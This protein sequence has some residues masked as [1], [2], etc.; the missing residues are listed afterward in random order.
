MI[1]NFPQAQRLRMKRA[2]IAST[3][4]TAEDD[5]LLADCAAGPIAI[6]LG[7]AADRSVDVSIKKVDATSNIVTITPTAPDT[8]DGRTS[9]TLT[10]ATM[11]S[12]T[13]TP[14]PSGWYVL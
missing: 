7:L 11:P 8:I 2:V 3:T 10:S 12:V 6:T 13:L 14:S 4:V 1:F 9:Y 5:V